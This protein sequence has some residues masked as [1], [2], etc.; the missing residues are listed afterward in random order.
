MIPVV[1]TLAHHLGFLPWLDGWS[2]ALW[3]FSLAWLALALWLG[4]KPRAAAAPTLARIDAAIRW[5]VAALFAVAALI[6]FARGVP[7]DAPWLA[8]KRLAFA[9]I[10]VLGILLCGVIREWA[11]GFAELRSAATVAAGNNRIARAHRRATWLAHTLWLLVARTARRRPFDARA[12]CADVGARHGLGR[13]GRRRERSISRLPRGACARWCGDGRNRV[14]ARACEHR[15]P[16]TRHSPRSRRGDTLARMRSRCDP[17][18]RRESCHYALARWAQ[19]QLAAL[20]VHGCAL[21]HPE[22]DG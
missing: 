5:I 22:H 16:R 14:G 10:I 2:P 17:R 20:A 15:K 9:A 13:W 6:S 11:L 12:S 21:A 18:V 8:G 7:V 3:L 4:V 1:A 19:R